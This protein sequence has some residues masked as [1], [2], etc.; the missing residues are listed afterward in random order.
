MGLR[1]PFLPWSHRPPRPLHL[2]VQKNTASNATTQTG[3]EV[4]CTS[5]A[6]QGDVPQRQL[7]ATTTLWKEGLMV[8]AHVTRLGQK[9]RSLC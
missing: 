6:P 2:Q 3:E 1:S 4:P 8:R 7:S 9:L 5:N